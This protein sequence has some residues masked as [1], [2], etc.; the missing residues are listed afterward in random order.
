V[1][2][3]LA[4][5]VACAS[6]GAAEPRS[7]AGDG[8]T[9]KPAPVAEPARSAEGS[10]LSTLPQQFPKGEWVRIE[11]PLLSM[12]LVTK[13]KVRGRETRATID[14]GAMSTVMSVPTATRL[15]V[16]GDFTPKGEKVRVYDAHGSVLE[17]ERL[18]LG[19]LQ[20]GEHKWL[21]ARVMVI[22]NQPELFLV[23]ADLL[24]DVDLFVAADEGLLGIFEA[25][26]APR[27]TS[28]VVI[29]LEKKERQLR[30]AARAPG[31]SGEVPFSLIVDTGAS[32]TTVPSLVGINGGLPADISY[33]SRTLAVGGEQ[34]NRGRF[35]LN[36]LSLGPKNAPVGRVLAMASAMQSGEG[37]GLLGNDVMMRQHSVLSFARGE[38]RLRRPLPRPATR[39]LGPGGKTCVDEKKREV[40]CIRVALRSPGEN[41]T[42]PDDA[43]TTACLEVKVGR[44][45]AGRTLELAVTALGDEGEH[46]F[47]GGAVRAFLTIGPDGEDGCFT[48]WKQLGRL[49]LEP[50]SKLSL[51]WVR[52]EGIIWPC[53]PMKT[54]CLSF[55][56]PLA[57]LDVR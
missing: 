10:D 27:E 19:E 30:V 9:A 22:G 2:L 45:Y 38:L 36:P 51:R 23:G 53:D 33:N 29:P 57:R 21:D 41:L 44:A 40:E 31:A 6:S 52:T 26:Q 34:E 18:Q 11:A 5:C 25:G 28:D 49:G 54:H 3:P 7:G 20:I 24:R 55:T 50:H 47:N 43:L 35:V 37:L 56:G 32:G 46:L 42:M 48:L 14:T 16:L 13:V 15:G 39:K 12:H 1:L 8:R 17:G 4:A